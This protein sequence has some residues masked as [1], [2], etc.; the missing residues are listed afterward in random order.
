MS[1]V[2]GHIL[3]PSAIRCNAQI[4]CR[5]KGYSGSADQKCP[6]RKWLGDLDFENFP[7][8]VCQYHKRR[9]RSSEVTVGVTP[10][11]VTIGPTK[12]PNMKSRPISNE[13]TL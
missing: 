11:F 10:P 4:G 12:L 13:P 5:P 1:P 8:N 9:S 3:G 6:E 2:R 7:L